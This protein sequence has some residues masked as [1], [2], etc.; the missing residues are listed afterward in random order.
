MTKSKKYKMQQK[1]LKS[2]DNKKSL[3][4]LKEHTTQ[5]ARIKDVEY[6]I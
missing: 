6:A 2:I 4:I 3:K 1:L 5:Y